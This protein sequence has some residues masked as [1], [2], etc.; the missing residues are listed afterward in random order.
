MCQ[1]CPQGS[2]S[3][4]YKRLIHIKACIKVLKSFK[5]TFPAYVCVRVCASHSV[6]SDFLQPRGWYATSLL[7]PWHS[8][9]KTTGVG[10]AI[11]F[12]RD[13]SPPRDQTRVS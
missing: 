8:P 1:H 6:M 10:V 13:S 5:E 3:H 9:G 7:C 11:S 2:Y 12:S 4:G